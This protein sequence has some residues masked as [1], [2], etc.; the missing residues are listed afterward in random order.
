MT[1]DEARDRLAF[2][3]SAEPSAF[4]GSLRARTLPPE[5]CFLEIMASIEAVSSLLSSATVER[6]LISDLWDIAWL[7]RLWFFNPLAIENGAL[8]KVKGIELSVIAD[9]LDR[10]GEAVSYGLG[11]NPEAVTDAMI[12]YE[13]QSLDYREIMTKDNSGKPHMTENK[14]SLT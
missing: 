13:R 9:W 4:L 14:N 8:E 10:L 6:Q 12:E 7:P 2:H 3:A 1:P 11:G 5:A